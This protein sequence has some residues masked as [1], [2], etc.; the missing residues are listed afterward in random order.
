M[1]NHEETPDG[2]L[3]PLWTPLIFFNIHI[4][5]ILAIKNIFTL[6]F[7]C[8]T[9]VQHNNV[10]DGCIVHSTEVHLKWNVAFIKVIKLLQCTHSNL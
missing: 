4:A 1:L 9:Q 10:N 7:T 2:P 3:S 8:K 5:M 6:F